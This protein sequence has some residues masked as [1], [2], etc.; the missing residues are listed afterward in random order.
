VK[1]VVLGV[2]GATATATVAA[3]A[4]SQVATAANTGL[5]ASEWLVLAPLLLIGLPLLSIGGAFMMVEG[6]THAFSRAL[7]TLTSSQMAKDLF[8]WIAEGAKEVGKWLSSTIKLMDSFYK[9]FKAS[10][11]M[12]MV[13]DIVGSSVMILLKPLLLLVDF[14][15][16]VLGNTDAIK[17]FIDPAMSVWKKI[18]DAIEWLYDVA[19]AIYDILKNPNKFIDEQLKKAGE[20]IESEI[21]KLTGFDLKIPQLDWTTFI[22]PLA[23]PNFIGKLVWDNIIPSGMFAAVGG[24]VESI[25]GIT[26]N[27][28]GN[29]LGIKTHTA[30]QTIS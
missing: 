25:N 17:K 18:L 22:N 5:D 7:K 8:K 10:G 9:G 13:L 4:A 24:L 14:V 12:K 21:K 20:A 11:Q 26:A 6:K 3:A 15:H 1:G 29:P 23:W 2:M 19:K 28:P 16:N 27:I 30:N